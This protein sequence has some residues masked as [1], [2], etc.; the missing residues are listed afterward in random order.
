M[1][2]AIKNLRKIFLLAV[3][4][5]SIFIWYAVFDLEARGNLSISFFDVG[6][7][8]SEFIQAE[9][10]N[11]VL[12][13]G[14][15]NEAILSKLGEAMP[16]WDRSID[17]VVLTH[18]H[19]DHLDGLL[20]VLKRYNVRT[21]IESGANHSIPE[22]AKWH[23]LLEEKAVEVIIAKA[24]QKIKISDSAYLNIFTP[25]EDFEDKSSKNIHDAMIA[26]KL[27]YGSTSV[28]FMGDA[29]KQIEY[30]L[31]FSGADL[32]SDILKVGHH[33]SKTSTSEEFLKAVS[34]KFAIISAGRK[35]RY[36]HPHQDILDRLMSFG[37]KIFRTDQDGDI[38]FLSDGT[39][40]IK[41]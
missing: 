13:D 14:V 6:Q 12:I 7:G 28:L 34:P 21:V 22:Y 25:F 18:P 17:L 10:G 41:N 37:I 2:I 8:D 20:E 24:G 27:N 1:S 33:G 31:I 19:A 23:Q 36:G 29:E 35:N 39:A 9:N 16:F 26:S 40:F 32:K 15:P 30:R 11:Q 4:A 3:I 38:R 5:A